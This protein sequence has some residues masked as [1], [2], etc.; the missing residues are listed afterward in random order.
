MSFTVVP[1]HNISLPS[2]T[3]VPF[4]KFAIQDVPDWLLKDSILDRLSAQDRE[5]VHRAKQ[6]LVTEYF[7]DSFGYPD[8]DW[9]GQKPKGI[10]EL[11]WQSALLANMCIWMVMPSAV[12]LSCGFH[13][14]TVLAGTKLESPFCNGTERE[15]TLYCHERDLPNE[16]TITTL[17]KSAKLFEILSIVPRKN[18]VWPA[19]RAFW[20][21]LTSFP[22][23]LRYPL[24]W[25]GLESLFGSDNETYGVSK[26]L[27]D[28]VSHFLADNPKDQID[29]H[30]K[31]KACYAVRSE[32]VHGR[33]ED[34]QAFHDIH[35]Y[36][37]EAIV[38]T[39]VRK[40]ADTPGMLGAFL[41]PQRDDFLEAWVVSKAFTAPP[42]PT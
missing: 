21:A 25:Q 8:P 24:F 26:R 40:M 23:D 27:R 12:C 6:A 5:S 38:R 28:R 4:G 41:S 42:F 39:V 37:T 11:R 33:W 13:A 35:M 19:L 36:T 29:I 22:G 17:N 32:I 16:P 3:V 9:R 15:T 1:L 14:L 7:A 30:D 18:S 34:S 20:A 2:G 31:V 10:Q